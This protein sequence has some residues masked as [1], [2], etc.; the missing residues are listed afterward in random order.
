M[1][2]DNSPN[3]ADLAV[4]GILSSIE[5]CNAFNDAIKNTKIGPW[6]YE[7]HKLVSTHHGLNH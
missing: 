6:Y 2:G 3:L 5:G 7:M 1:G 4:Y